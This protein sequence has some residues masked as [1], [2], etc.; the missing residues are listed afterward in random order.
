M[1][2]FLL[3]IFVLLVIPLSAT[4]GLQEYALRQ[5][6]N[7]YAYKNDWL[8]QNAKHVHV[9]TLGSSHGLY[10]FQPKE[11]SKPTFNAGHVSQSLR[12]DKFILEK[13]IETM[14]SLEYVI[15]PVS[16]FAIRSSGL[17]GGDEW[18]RVKNY[19][20]YYGCPY[21]RNEPKYALEC[22][23]F[24]PK[25]TLKALLGKTDHLDV[26]SLGRGLAYSYENKDKEHWFENGAQRAKYH[27]KN[28]DDAL[29]QQNVGYI[30][31][32][33]ELCRKKDVKLVLVTTPNFHTY[34]DNLDQDQVDEMVQVCSNFALQN[35]NVDY[36]N[37]MANEDFVGDDFF[38]SDHL[39]DLGAIKLS[40]LLDAYLDSK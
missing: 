31:S 13:F 38:D 21:H 40:R 33:I 11:F 18:W 3:R 20:I 29:V 34:R 37:W 6:P 2:K 36:L 16:Y 7:D 25:G 24:S 14:D 12:Y 26:D 39:C 35:S 10:G 30:S 28:R 22:Y 9:L 4:M 17:E 19:T 1:K 23:Q 15:L 8:T 32:I 27:T 5:I